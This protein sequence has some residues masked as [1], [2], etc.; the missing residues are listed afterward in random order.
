VESWL[1][2]W[3]LVCAASISDANSRLTDMW[4]RK[5]PHADPPYLNISKEL[6]KDRLDES[7]CRPF[8]KYM[9]TMS[10][11]IL[12]SLRSTNNRLFIQMLQSHV[13]NYVQE[14]NKSINEERLQDCLLLT[15]LLIH[16]FNGNPDFCAVAVRF[17]THNHV[18]NALCKW[19]VKPATKTQDYEQR[20][21]LQYGCALLLQTLLGIPI[22]REGTNFL[23]EDGTAW[24]EDAKA[25]VRDLFSMHKV[26]NYESMSHIGCTELI[27][28]ALGFRPKDEDI[29]KYTGCLL[30]QNY[31]YV[32]F[33]DFSNTIMRLYKS[34]KFADTLSF[35]KML[36]Y[37]GRNRDLS[38]ANESLD[39]ASVAS[40]IS[41]Q[42]MGLDPS[43]IDF[44][45][46][47]NMLLCLGEIDQGI[48]N[49]VLQRI[50]SDR[51]N[52]EKYLPEFI[53]SQVSAF[54]GRNERSSDL[55]K[56][57]LLDLLDFIPEESEEMIDQM[58]GLMFSHPE[59]GFLCRMRR[60][61][62]EGR[63]ADV[64][65][66]V[67][68][69]QAICERRP[70]FFNKLMVEV[71][72]ETDFNVGGFIKRPGA[73]FSENEIIEY[74]EYS[75][76]IKSSARPQFNGTYKFKEI[77]N[78]VGCYS[79]NIDENEFFIV[80]G[81][82]DPNTESRRWAIGYRNLLT[83]VEK[84]M[85]YLD[86]VNFK[87]FHPKN[88]TRFLE[89]YPSNYYLNDPCR[90]YVKERVQ[91]SISLNASYDDNNDIQDNDN[92]VG[93]SAAS[94]SASA[95]FPEDASRWSS[96]NEFDGTQENIHDFNTSN[97]DFDSNDAM[98]SDSPNQGSRHT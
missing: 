37:A 46:R 49:S 5:E 24:T 61:I 41:L 34:K 26:S 52:M 96:S 84:E 21:E 51:I 64:A 19:P 48:Y 8:A 71:D 14:L 73:L 78:E 94:A 20:V 16:L 50:L 86:D 33:E 68:I 88:D 81:P 98:D 7:F 13:L 63:V 62:V 80:A 36:R 43:F 44:I 54:T 89:I 35:Y 67:N 39:T 69:I 11:E 66:F 76:E 42:E 28:N 77:R 70:C 74:K 87:W 91:Q 32:Y 55:A 25:F 82:K 45:V 90:L 65:D 95:D 97:D 83:S 22:V 92:H 18:Y 29:L 10:I 15:D 57:K 72:R 56:T 53:S 30:R 12:R 40:T 4:E 3:R 17:K 60:L 6:S 85:F 93:P 23:S 38:K 27:V 59:F 75:M 58:T 1:D 47:D 2:Q 9:A 31:Y 79:K